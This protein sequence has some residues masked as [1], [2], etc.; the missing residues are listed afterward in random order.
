MS[1]PQ[2]ARALKLTEQLEEVLS[3]VPSPTDAP[4]LQA[5]VRT[6]ARE[7]HAAHVE[8]EELEAKRG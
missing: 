2:L 7:I 1:G 3:E 6:I 4:F 8:L 5:E